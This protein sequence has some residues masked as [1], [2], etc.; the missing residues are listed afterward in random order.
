MNSGYAARGVATAVALSAM[1]GSAFALEASGAAPGP[2]DVEPF[3]TGLVAIS[4]SG[5]H[6]TALLIFCTLYG[7]RSV[8]YAFD[9]TGMAS[10]EIPISQVRV[11]LTPMI[12]VMGLFVPS[13]SA[14]FDNDGYVIRM[15]IPMP[16]DFEPAEAE[17][18]TIASGPGALPANRWSVT[19][20]EAGLDDAVRIAFK[21][22]V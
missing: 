11:Q 18:M 5:D 9:G 19:L 4:R 16:G 13:R 22:C 10:E 2:W 20:N 3:K 15:Q 1:S 12:D 8:V 21:N 14:T 17:R 7:M 6:R